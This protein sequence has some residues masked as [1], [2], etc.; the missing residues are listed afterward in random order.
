VTGP[1]K[2]KAPARETSP[3]VL[4]R[5]LLR[6]AERRIGANGVIDLSCAPDAVDVYMAKLEAFWRS[7]GRPFPEEKLA[8]LRDVL[9]NGLRT[10]NATSPDAR[11][12]IAF[13]SEPRPAPTLQYEA[14][15][16]NQTIA[17]RYATW[18][19][20]RT[21][22]LFGKYPDSKLVDLARSL[23]EPSSVPLLDLGA[24]TGRNALAMAERGYPT[25]VVEPVAEF[26]E[27]IR[28]R[29]AASELELEIIEGFVESAAL[30]LPRQRF[31]LAVMAEVVTDFRGVDTLRAA[32]KKLSEAIVPGGLLLF[33][34]F[35]MKGDHAVDPLTRQVS[36]IRGAS[37]FTRAEFALIEREFPFERVSDESAHDYERDHLPPDGWPPT[38]W[39]ERWAQAQDVFDVPADQSPAE[40]RWLVYRRLG[41]E[42]PPDRSNRPKTTVQDARR[43]PWR[44]FVLRTLDRTIRAKGVLSLPCLPAMLDDYMDRL[45]AAWGAVGKPFSA[46]ELDELR[47]VL[48]GG[49]EA[50]HRA[51]PHAV[52]T[53]D[54]ES[55][56]PP[57]GKLTYNVRFSAETSAEF[58]AEWM[59]RRA[60]PLDPTGPDAKVID[61]AASLGDPRLVSVLDVDSGG[62]RNALALAA[63]GHP[64]TA[65]Q[66]D[67]DT[68]RLLRRAAIGA[69]VAVEVLQGDIA[70]PSPALPPGRF[71][72]AV[73]SGVFTRH[74]AAERLRL[75]F[76]KL[77]HAVAPKGLVLFNAFIVD[78]GYKPDPLARQLAA[79]A[80]AFMLGRSDLEFITREFPFDEVSSESAL[81]YEQRHTLGAIWPPTGWF[82]DWAQG[83]EIFDLPN[84][85]APV[86]LK[87]LVYRR[88]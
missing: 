70:A 35:L 79:A 3:A 52:L 11:L 12:R 57:N 76:D 86:E 85:R 15:L 63:R 73:L 71:K 17:E 66:P 75:T 59:L 53:F 33:N 32:L 58:H 5:A 65:V 40:L 4:R 37:M 41:G 13:V 55:Q 48:A 25:T 34:A 88:R 16:F 8:R 39:F 6:A 69:R 44:P 7:I 56:P 31:K 47:G 67:P 54:Y 50:G 38:G 72:L 14:R 80:Q 87:W 10:G 28:K 20:E 68:A 49:L 18:L 84:G 83:R 23:G 43:V 36:D 46:E 27:E 30:E 24:G 74:E 82:V 26:A 19:A 60:P 22:P 78:G 9:V 29:A 45:A 21:P 2:Q 64:T 61:L 1:A 51:S 42:A 77:A 62:G 81:Q